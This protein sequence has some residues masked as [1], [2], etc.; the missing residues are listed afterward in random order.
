[1]FFGH[2]SESFIWIEIIIFDL[3]TDGQ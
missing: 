2:Y 3:L 1:L